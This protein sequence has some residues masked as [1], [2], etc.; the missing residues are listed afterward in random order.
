MSNRRSPEPFF[1]LLFSGGGMVAAILA[2]VLLFLFGVAIPL[3]WVDTPTYGHLSGVVENP[4]TR[5]ALFGFCVLAL[6]HWAHRFRYTLKDG[7]QL[8]HRLDVVITWV[9]YG[10]AIGGSAMAGYLF[11]TVG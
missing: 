6:F 2:P 11:V 10:G 1:W 5:I 9:C 4:L 8:K 3:D 7:L